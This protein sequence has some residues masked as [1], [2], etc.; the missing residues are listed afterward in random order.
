MVRPVGIA[1][2]MF[3]LVYAAL[4]IV[5]GQRIVLLGDLA[6]LVPPLAY[7][8]LALWLGR[9]SR[10]QVRVFWNLNAIHGL[11]WSFGQVVW[12]YYHHVAGGVPVISPTDPLFFVSSIP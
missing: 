8:G 5:T 10:G 4:S 7:A 2:A 11:M 9:Q 3:L 12:T 6:Q 1:G